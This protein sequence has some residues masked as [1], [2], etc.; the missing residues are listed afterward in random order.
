MRIFDATMTKG[1]LLR[2]CWLLCSPFWGCSIFAYAGDAW[3]PP[4]VTAGQQRANEEIKRNQVRIESSSIWIWKFAHDKL[5][6]EGELPFGVPGVQLRGP[7]T[8]N[9]VL[10]FQKL[11]APYLDKNYFKKNPK[12]KWYMPNPSDVG[13]WVNL[14]S[15]GGD[16][17]AAMAIGRMFRKARVWAH[18]GWS[19]KCMSSCVLLLAGAVKRST[20]DGGPVGIHRPY[21]TET[22]AASFEELQTKTTK[23]GADVAAYL[24]EMNIPSSLYESMRLVPPESI[25]ILGLSELEKFGLYDADPVFAELNDNSEAN[26]AGLSKQEF[27]SRK[28]QSRKCQLDG[29]KAL[30]VR[31]NDTDEA[32]EVARIARECAL[33][34]IYR[35][36]IDDNGTWRAIPSD[37]SCR[38][39]IDDT[40]V[41]L[42][43]RDWGRVLKIAKERERNCAK[44]MSANELADS[45]NDQADAHLELGNPKEASSVASRCLRVAN[46]P[47]CHITKGRAL[48]ILSRSREGA[49]E[50]G[51]GKRLADEEVSRLS[52]DLQRASSIA[53]KQSLE[54]QVD[55]YKSLARFAQAILTQ[56]TQRPSH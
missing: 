54:S 32:L 22:G 2:L 40:T 5:M 55:K 28:A 20:F 39:L 42:T 45:I 46:I 18:V 51:L 47:D 21:S 6:N 1:Y 24:Q 16:V 48:L 10:I 17:Y 31:G 49:E 53:E 8:K 36:V 52:R 14:D 29:F 50:V 56:T 7:I 15:E 33:K 27:M 44:K 11:L 38:S 25:K 23:L 35:D 4:V 34:T 13:Y 26:L 30:K 37:S 43:S 41:A 9:D 3:Q 19:G 12:P